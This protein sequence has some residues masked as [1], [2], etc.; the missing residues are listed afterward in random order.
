MFKFFVD[1]N[2]ILISFLLSILLQFLATL[3]STAK[4]KKKCENNDKIKY[5]IF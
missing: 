3:E 5:F 4:K 1:F 2:V